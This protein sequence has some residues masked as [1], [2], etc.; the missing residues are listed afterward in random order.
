MLTRCSNIF[1][2]RWTRLLQTLGGVEG[3]TCQ[4]YKVE[5]KRELSQLLDNEEF[6]RADK[7]QL[8]E[9]IMPVMDAPRAL[10]LQAELSGLSNKYTV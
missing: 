9:V 4:S 1:N 2:R 7:I 5:T 6:A 8:V 3:E 10:K